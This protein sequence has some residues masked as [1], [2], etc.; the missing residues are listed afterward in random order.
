MDSKRESYP[1]DHVSQT[2]SKILLPP[3]GTTSKHTPDLEPSPL[4]S[5]EDLSA[6]PSHVR[7]EEDQRSHLSTLDMNYMY[8]DEEP[9]FTSHQEESLH[10][11]IS[12]KA[13]NGTSHLVP[14]S[15]VTNRNIGYDLAKVDSDNIE[16]VHDSPSQE[17]VATT[18]MK[19]DIYTQKTSDAM[20]SVLRAMKQ[21]KADSI[22]YRLAQGTGND[23]NVSLR[24]S[25]RHK[26]IRSVIPD[27]YLYFQS[28]SIMTPNMRASTLQR[29]TKRGMMMEVSFYTY[30][31]NI[32]A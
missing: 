12:F 22:S 2:P 31:S 30:A 26:L 5:Y 3:L 7:P 14:Q 11:T 6:F 27:P 20:K 17:N 21:K 29:Y 9:S 24:E 13:A 1:Y 23:S 25:A 32:F 4:S 10:E 28:L 15:L 19:D 8:E 16:R 18:I